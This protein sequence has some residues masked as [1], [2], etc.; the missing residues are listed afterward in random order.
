[1]PVI[2]RDAAAGS[3]GA[4]IATMRSTRLMPPYFAVP[5]FTSF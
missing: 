5:A 2:A 4:M 3:N 1:M